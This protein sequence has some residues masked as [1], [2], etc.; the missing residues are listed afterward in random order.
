MLGRYVPVRAEVDV[1]RNLSVHADADE[2]VA[3][4]DG[5]PEPPGIVFVVHGEESA[6]DALAARLGDAGH[7]AVVPRQHERVLVP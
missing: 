1:L 5:L 2:L 3:W 7:V 4:V 6:S